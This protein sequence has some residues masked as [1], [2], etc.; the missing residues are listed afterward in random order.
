MAESESNF[1][2]TTDILYLSLMGEL[3]GVYCEYFGENWLRYNGTTLY[4]ATAQKNLRML[5]SKN[6]TE[7]YLFS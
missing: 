7:V 6:D 4:I 2:I 3:W 5:S 1:R